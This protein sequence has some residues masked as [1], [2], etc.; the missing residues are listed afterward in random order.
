[1]HDTEI[2]Q[3]SHAEDLAITKKVIAPEDQPRAADVSSA[4]STLEE[5]ER[6]ALATNPAIKEIDAEIEALQGKLTQAGLPPNPVVGI[7]GAEIGEDGGSGRYGVYFGREI[8]RGNKLALSRSVVCAE[9]EAGRQR[10]SVIEQK[11]LTDVRQAFFNALITQKRVETIEQLV[12]L[13]RQAV[14]TSEKLVAADELA[15]TSLLQ[16]QLEYQNSNVLIRQARNRKLAADRQLAALI[17]KAELSQ[18][19][20]VGEVRLAETLDAFEALFD[21]LLASSP[22]VSSLFAEVE[23]QQRNLSRQTAE[24]IPNLTWQSTIQYDTVSDNV[25]TG[26]QLGMPTPTLNQNQGAVYQARHKVISAQRRVEKKTLSL[27]QQLTKTYQDYIDAQIQV[28]A[29]E[30]KIIPGATKTVELIS[31]AYR[32]GET[33]F[34]QW[35][36]V[37]RT[38]SQ[39]QLTYLDQLQIL[40]DRHWTLKGMLLSGSLKD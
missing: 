24:P 12:Q 31:E 10:R 27:R 14:D 37:Q 30:E 23:R 19:R 28:T 39:T 35:L 36:T 9:I 5:Y 13:S 6:L 29:F 38:Y 21:Q 15:T 22:E 40:W 7:N 11:V 25:V 8:V 33:P 18:G 3:V 34:L 17:G 20:L 4:N 2:L 26:I 16:A 1:M 32:Q